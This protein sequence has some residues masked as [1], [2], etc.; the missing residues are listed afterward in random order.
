MPA[1]A[2]RN[3]VENLPPPPQ[4]SIVPSTTLGK[5]DSPAPAVDTTL[6]STTPARSSTSASTLPDTTHDTMHDR[7][8]PPQEPSH[9]RDNSSSVAALTEPVGSRD[10]RGGTTHGSRMF[11]GSCARTPAIASASQP[12]DSVTEES[13]RPLP[14][15]TRGVPLSDRNN[16]TPTPV[17]APLT[18]EF[19]VGDAGTSQEPSLAS[20]QPSSTSPQLRDSR[21]PAPTHVRSEGGKKSG[22]P[23]TQQTILQEVQD[24]ATSCGHSP[25]RSFPCSRRQQL[26]LT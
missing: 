10:D 15:Q 22:A 4:P 25:S 13:G 14:G 26:L 24:F 3:S 21:L 2:R 23:D 12:T 1:P 20:G 5:S 9:A 7:G 19:F 8:S 6:V 18:T 11:R 16:R 17:E